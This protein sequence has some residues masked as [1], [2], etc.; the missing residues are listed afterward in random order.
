MKIIAIIQA[1]MN[2]TRL[3]FKSATLLCGKPMTQHILERVKRAHML[4]AVILAIPNEPGNGIL[5]K[6]AI[7][8][9]AELFVADGISDNDLLRRY[10]QAAESYKPQLV[11]RVAAD[12]P[13]VQ[14]SEIDRILQERL[15]IHSPV[16]A[17][18]TNMQEVK[19]NG[20]PDGIG[21]EVYD[22]PFLRWLD[23]TQ[24]DPRYREHPHLWAYEH[25]AVETVLC[26]RQFARPELRL[27]VN[28]QEDFNFIRDIYEHCYP[29]NNNFGIT[30]I[31]AYLDE[32]NLAK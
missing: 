16:R 15:R 13:C 22:M 7:S 14:A 29:Q 17:L 25:N 26:P 11:V 8:T 1:R 27:D 10:V 24:T 21:A 18:Y 19:R 2:S 9:G 23:A 32:R 3:P 28:T 4:D 6:C 30:D 12:N 5:K 20:Y 31:L